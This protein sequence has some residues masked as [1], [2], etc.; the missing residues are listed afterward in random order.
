MYALALCA[1]LLAGPTT[2]TV[3]DDGPAD[4]AS[5]SDAVSSP[6][7]SDGDTLLVYHGSY[8]AFTLDREL[9]IVAAA[10]DIFLVEG[11]NVIGA[12]TFTI[13]GMRTENT[14]VIGVSGRGTFDDCQ[15]GVLEVVPDWDI[16][17]QG[18][19]E[20]KSCA[21]LLVTRSVFHGAEG[22]YPDL[23][24]T[25]PALVVSSS[26]LA[27]VD[28]VLQGG[29]DDL[30]NGHPTDGAKPALDTSNSFVTISGCSLYGGQG[31]TGLGFPGAPAIEMSGV[32]R[33]RGSFH[34]VVRGGSGW[35]GLA[36]PF[37]GS[38]TATISGVRY[39]PFQLPGWVTE[40]SPAEPYLLV[41]GDDTPGATKTIELYGPPGRGARVFW[42]DVPALQS[43][44]AGLDPLWFDREQ[45]Q[46]G[47]YLVAVGQDH[48]ATYSFPLPATPDPGDVRI[49]QAFLPGGSGY[50]RFLT[51]PAQVLY[52]W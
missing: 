1:L 50:V 39:N 21:E 47:T 12:P 31:I 24:W 3:D 52:R 43:L 40:P 19:T 48:P 22:C 36:P 18:S 35:G 16:V 13:A 29:A 14:L 27:L 44:F 25:E 38:G 9:R 23:T 37:A 7:V 20:F 15:F 34:H 41:T 51:S 30:C 46:G 11:C 6:L 26:N 4:F 10:G 28:C 5:I 2:W 42:S 49:Y 45:V 8:P 32:V 17:W 33:V